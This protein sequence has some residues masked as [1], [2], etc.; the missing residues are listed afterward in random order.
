MKKTILCL[1][2]SIVLIWCTGCMSPS[3]MKKLGDGSAKECA[4]KV[5]DLINANDT[6][7]LIALFSETAK[8]NENL[9]S[10]IEEMY[11]YIGGEIVSYDEYIQ[12]SG[13][14]TR[15]DGKITVQTYSPTIKNAK[16]QNGASYQIY[17]SFIGI[18]LDVP[19]QEGV[20]FIRISKIDSND[21]IIDGEEVIV[22]DPDLY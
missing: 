7:G 13:G 22:G 9:V 5:V 18:Y 6:E 11:D 10:Q 19:Q 16:T 20:E 1:L 21:E 2:I 3:E 17:I 12:I 8:G 4:K 14:E 15:K